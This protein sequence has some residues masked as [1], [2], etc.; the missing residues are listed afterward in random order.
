[1]IV[2]RRVSSRRRRVGQERRPVRI[3]ENPAGRTW[4]I[5]QQVHV[6]AEIAL[7]RWD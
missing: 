1:M 3:A 6:P 2:V 7:N 5:S 4:W